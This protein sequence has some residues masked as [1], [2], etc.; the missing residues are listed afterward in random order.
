[1]STPTVL[2]FLNGNNPQTI[3]TGAN[4]NALASGALVL[5]SN[6]SNIQLDNAGGGYRWARMKW[7]VDSMTVSA[8]GLGDGWFLTASDASVYEQGGTSVVPQRAPD[9]I[10]LPVPQTA[11]IDLEILVLV[12][13]CANIKCLFRNNALGAALPSNNNAY[14]KLYYETDQIPSV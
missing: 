10:L 1:M 3:I 13:I 5:G 8:G 2:G 6:F 12:P 11:A 9:F 14:L 4:Q 7:H